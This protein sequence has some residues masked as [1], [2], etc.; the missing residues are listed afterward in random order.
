MHPDDWCGSNVPLA[1]PAPEPEPEPQPLKLPA[2]VAPGW[3][4][5]L[6]W[7]IVPGVATWRL[8]H[9]DGRVRFAKVTAGSVFPSLADEA[10]RMQWAAAHLPVP[11]VV[12]LERPAGTTIL[13]TEGLAGR[14]GTD[15]LW[16]R[17]LPGLVQAFGRGLRQFHD[18]VEA[19]RCPYRF[20]LDEALAHVRRRVAAGDVHPG[21]FHPEHAHFTP[22]T[23]LARLEA[24]LPQSEDSVVCHG[25]YCPPN[26]LLTDGR[27]T[28]YVDLGELGVADR[29]WDVAIGGWSTGWNFGSEF[30]PGFY[31]AYGIEPDL[32]RIASYRL[33]YDLVS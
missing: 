32:E 18:A 15:P 4:P 9:R 2:G 33:L 13:V 22:E 17:D 25:D 31:A 5:S 12:S 7:R 8:T 19:R 10:E 16:R 30:E 3:Q 21:G 1:A 27:V 29:W 23:A 6:A 20:G 26:V 28:G 14:D 11:R 24:T